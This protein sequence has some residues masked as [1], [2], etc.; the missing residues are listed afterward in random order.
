MRAMLNK[1]IKVDSIVKMINSITLAFFMGSSK[2]VKE[3][4]IKKYVRNSAILAN[5]KIIN[6]IKPKMA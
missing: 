4:V 3:S 5:N 2:K 1:E 6:K